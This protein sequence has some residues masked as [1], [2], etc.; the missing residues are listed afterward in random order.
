M[1]GIFWL[2]EYLLATQEKSCSIESFFY[3]SN[4]T[5]E[6]G[7]YELLNAYKPIMVKVPLLSNAGRF[8]KDR[9]FVRLSGLAVCPD[10]SNVPMKVSMERRWKDTDWEKPKY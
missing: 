9:C 6:Y 10:N 7:V 8:P 1:R 5:T 2:A 4:S 3:Y